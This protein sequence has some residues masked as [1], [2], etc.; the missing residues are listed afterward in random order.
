MSESAVIL[1]R[2]A[3]MNVRVI[4][5][6][7]AGI[8]LT[9]T[10]VKSIRNGHADINHAFARVEKEGVVL[11]GSHVDEYEQGN[12]FNHDPK[13]Q[14]RLLIHRREIFRLAEQTRSK[15]RSLVPLKIYFNAK[16]RAKVQLALCEG[17][18]HEDR[19]QDIKARDSKREID[20]MLKNR[21]A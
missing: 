11:Y 12:R 19:R 1:N 6:L 2:R 14:R 17:K 16:G 9:G 5:T 18:T 10:E 3:R 7:E 20:R 8:V 4:E 21:K 13:R 15:G